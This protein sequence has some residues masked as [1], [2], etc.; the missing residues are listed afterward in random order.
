MRHAYVVGV[1]TS[2]A[3]PNPKESE[4]FLNG[5]EA[6]VVIIL[7]RSTNQVITEVRTSI[8]L[9][10]LHAK[11]IADTLENLYFPYPFCRIRI[12]KKMFGSE[13]ERN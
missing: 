2:V 11:R 4:K 10:E 5:M 6:N 8:L 1:T 3:D 7:H 9:V 12:P 13:S